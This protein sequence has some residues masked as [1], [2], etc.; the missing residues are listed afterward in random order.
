[1]ADSAAI[2][3]LID[4]IDSHLAE[5]LA[6]AIYRTLSTACDRHDCRRRKCGCIEATGYLRVDVGFWS[7]PNRP[8]MVTV[9]DDEVVELVGGFKKNRKLSKSWLRGVR[10]SQINQLDG[11]DRQTL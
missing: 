10:S 2:D 8:A 4:E 3:A 6:D 7:P 11:F 5:Q 1:M 9:V